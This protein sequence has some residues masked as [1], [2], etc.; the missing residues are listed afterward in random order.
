VRTELAA[1]AQYYADNQESITEAA[2]FIPLSEEQA[3][4]QQE[5]LNSIVGA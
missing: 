3:A 4:S 2:L 1:F 5:A